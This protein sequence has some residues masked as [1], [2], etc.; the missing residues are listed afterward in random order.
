MICEIE[1]VN[2]N[3]NPKL[4]I[5]CVVLSL[6]L[7]LRK[8]AMNKNLNFGNCCLIEFTELKF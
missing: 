8:I 5:N 6:K 4:F 3:L 2:I 1:L 7:Y